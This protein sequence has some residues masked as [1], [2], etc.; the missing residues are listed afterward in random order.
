MEHK[1]IEQDLALLT[2]VYF[3]GSISDVLGQLLTDDKDVLIRY[4]TYV[5]DPA[6]LM[7]MLLFITK[8]RRGASVS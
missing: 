5:S 8:K 6:V 3:T 2:G 1:C 4:H 7:S